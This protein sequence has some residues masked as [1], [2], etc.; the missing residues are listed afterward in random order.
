MK[1]IYILLLI[2]LVLTACGTTPQIE[3]TEKPTQEIVPTVPPPPTEPPVQE[4]RITSADEIVGKWEGKYL[5]YT[6]PHEFRADGLLIVSITGKYVISKGKYWFEDGL[7]KMNDREGD[8]ADMLGV[9]EVYATYEG[10][11]PTKLRFVLVG[12]DACESR[13]NTLA[14]GLLAVPPAPTP[15]AVLPSETRITAAEKL[16]GVW[17]GQS[18][19]YTVLHKFQVDGTC[20]VNVSGVGVIGRGPYV[21]E[22]DLLKFQDTLGDCEG[23]VATYEVY[24]IY[25]DGQ[26][27][28]LRFVLVGDD[29]C[30]DRRRTLDGRTLTLN[31]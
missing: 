4:I 19:G 18:G 23:I 5:S 30:A 28:G 17:K 24:G 21:F 22:N 31:P 10:D 6:L 13:K 9:Y 3:P 2:A 8:C 16:V 14:G 7:L 29:A 1:S 27:T 12:E 20:V 11:R 26:L 15:A 25:T